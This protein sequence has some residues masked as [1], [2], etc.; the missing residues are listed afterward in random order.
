[1]KNAK[2]LLEEQKADATSIMLPFKHLL[3]GVKELVKKRLLS[4]KTVT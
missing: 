4:G 1:M 3:N 2:A